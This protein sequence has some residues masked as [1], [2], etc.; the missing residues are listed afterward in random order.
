MSGLF[1]AERFAMKEHLGAIGDKSTII[2]CTSSH[3]DGVDCGVF[4]IENNK[5]VLLLSTFLKNKEISN[6][7]DTITQ[8]L[9]Y[10][11]NTYGFNIQY[12]CFAGLGVPSANQDY[13]E[14]WR[15]PYVIDAKEIIAQNNLI[16]AIIV[17]D[18]LAMSYGIN[19]VDNKKITVLH[20][21]VP[22]KNGRRVI[23]G[24]GGGLGTVSMIWDEGKGAYVSFPAEAGTGDFPLFDAFELDLTLRMKKARNFQTCH[25]A[26]FVAQP[27]IQ[28]TYQILQD[29][30]YEGCASD[31]KYIDPMAIL[32]DADN[33][34]CCAKTADL[35]YKFYAR[36][37]YNFVW[38][39]LPFGGIYLVGETASMHPEMLKSIF[40]PEYF[41]CVE[42]KRPLLQRIPV[43]ILKDDVT[44]GLYG[45]AQYFLLE[46]KEFF[47]GESFL[48]VIQS[49][50]GCYWNMLK[51]KLQSCC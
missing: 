43:Y 45:I 51:N 20:D 7:T 9:S 49:K 4:S 8:L 36:F 42:S 2:L 5:P 46:K 14:H 50:V 35:F 48:D 15:L 23:I 40:L 6:F 11:K 13:L 12:A 47:K 31:K 24:A 37:V 25:W 26:F 41:N 3:G 27:G 10:L 38:N 34:V 30:N 29:I 44:V 21:A 39:T 32:A 28:Y 33:D 18:F 19:F 1:S 16:S 17:N 22:E